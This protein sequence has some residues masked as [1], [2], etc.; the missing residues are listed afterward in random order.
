MS[1]VAPTESLRF[2]PAAGVFDAGV[3][4]RAGLSVAGQP[5]PVRA[6]GFYTLAAV[7]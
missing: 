7:V 5:P 3:F 4:L 6:A 1:D 2:P